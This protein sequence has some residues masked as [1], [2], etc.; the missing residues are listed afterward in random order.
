MRVLNFEGENA[1]V[2]VWHGGEKSGAQWDWLARILS[3]N[4]DNTIVLV[5]MPS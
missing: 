5:L 1:P 4:L 3:R 2:Y